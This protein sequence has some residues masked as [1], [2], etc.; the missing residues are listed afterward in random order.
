MKFRIDRPIK[1]SYSEEVTY[2]V[3]NDFLRI[4]EDRKQ[5]GMLDWI[6][7]DD[8]VI[9]GWIDDDEI[10]HIIIKE[11]REYINVNTLDE[12]YSITKDNGDK[13]V[14]GTYKDENGSDGWIEIY[15]DYRE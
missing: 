13:I 5:Q 15:D 8:N 4:T 9:K 10:C 6:Q 1:D 3:T 11:T 7:L 14:F 2:E 12:L